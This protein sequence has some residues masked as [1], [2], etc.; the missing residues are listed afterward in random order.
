MCLQLSKEEAR[1][2]LHLLR[3]HEFFGWV[4]ADGEFGAHPSG[5]VDPD[6][7]RVLERLRGAVGQRA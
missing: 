5:E 4:E 7:I 1:A 3:A 2:L 6:L